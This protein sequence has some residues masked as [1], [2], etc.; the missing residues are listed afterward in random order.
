MT[1]RITPRMILKPH[2]VTQ[3]EEEVP[4][5]DSMVEGILLLEE[6]E[7]VEEER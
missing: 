4:K 6:G 3:K 7:E 1:R 2:P 5:G